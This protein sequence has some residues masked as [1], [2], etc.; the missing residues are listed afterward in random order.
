MNYLIPRVMSI[1]S[2]LAFVFLVYAPMLVQAATIL[3]A[4]FENKNF[5]PLDTEALCCDHSAIIVSIPARAGN[6]AAKVT[7]NSNDKGYI[8]G[9]WTDPAKRAELRKYNTGPKVGSERWYGVSMYVDPSWTDT[10]NDPNG[11]VVMQWHG[12]AGDPGEPAHSP[13][14]SI[15][16][17]K[18]HRWYV[19]TIYDANRIST[20]SSPTEI[21][22]DMGPVTNGVWVDWVIHVKWHYNSTGLLEVWKDG[23][24]VVHYSG[25]NTYN[26]QNE[27]AVCIGIYKS[28]YALEKPN[29]SNKLIMYFD[30]LKIADGASSYK[31]VAPNGSA[32]SKLPAPANLKTVSG[33]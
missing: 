7:L 13:Q 16:I 24:Q 32:V 26:D 11:T 27:V 3:A 8:F 12:V 5:S 4:D 2:F 28:W 1:T 33:M 20:S 6:Y 22:R 29:P 17:T 15:R 31:D 25:P 14:L 19:N 9:N 23:R 30:E 21:K 18:D 10:T